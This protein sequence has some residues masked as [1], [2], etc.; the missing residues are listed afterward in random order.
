[1]IQV[2]EPYWK[3][4]D[5]IH[6]M[7]DI[8]AREDTERLAALAEGL[9]GDCCRFGAVARQVVQAWPTAAAV[10]LTA[11]GSNRRAWVGQASCSFSFG[12]PEITTRVAWKNL[13][14]NQRD[15]ANDVADEVIREYEREYCALHRRVEMSRLFGRDS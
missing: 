13:T 10:N 14:Q 3:W 5:F 2:F 11:M 12:S 15:S 1:M 8:P 6:G 7:Y 4:E 9:L